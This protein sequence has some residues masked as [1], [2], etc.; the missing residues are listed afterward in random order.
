MGLQKTT[1]SEIAI[2][3]ALCA[4]A[5][6]WDSSNALFN[7][8]LNFNSSRF[9]TPAACYNIKREVPV[10]SH[11]HAPDHHPCIEGTMADH[12]FKPAQKTHVYDLLG[13]LNA[14][15]A[16]VARN[17]PDHEI[18]TMRKLNPIRGLR[19]LKRRLDLASVLRKFYSCARGIFAIVY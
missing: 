1:R 2:R 4:R 16:R 8:F 18:H 9:P 5:A 11:G 15:F 12:D 6:F 17:M 7:T 13:R 10:F 14:S 3:T 19:F